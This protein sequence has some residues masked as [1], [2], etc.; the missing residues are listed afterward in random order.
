[1]MKVLWLEIIKTLHWIRPN[2]TQPNLIIQSFVLYTL[3]LRWANR[4]NSKPDSLV[5]TFL[6][7]SLAALARSTVMLNR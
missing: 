3:C 4:T 5:R 6:V 2:L 7:A 1:M